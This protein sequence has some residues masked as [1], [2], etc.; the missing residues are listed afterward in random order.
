MFKARKGTSLPWIRF[1]M[2]TIF[3]DSDKN[4]NAEQILNFTKNGAVALELQILLNSAQ[5]NWPLLLKIILMRDSYLSSIIFTHLIEYLPSSD[6][7]KAAL[8]QPFAKDEK[9]AEKCER[10]LCGKECK[11]VAEWASVDDG[12]RTNK[13][14][15]SIEKIKKKY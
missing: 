3:A 12:N 1:S 6:C 14:I 11:N 4:K 8:T 13:L 2:P 9:D 5:A 15:C 7:F 10:F